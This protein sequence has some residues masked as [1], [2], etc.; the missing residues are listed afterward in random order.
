MR[1]QYRRYAVDFRTPLRT[2]AGVWTRREGLIVRAEQ[3]DGRVG[4]GE[5]APVP[6]FGM[7]TAAELAEFA[8]SLPTLTPAEVRPEI[9]PRLPTLAHAVAAAAAEAS[10]PLES[11]APAPGA[12]ERVATLQV[13]ALLPAGKAA[14][15]AAAARLESEFRVLKWK[16]G[17]GD[18]RDEVGLLDELCALLPEGARL[19]LDANGAWD[20]RTAERWLERCAE[21]PI[22][23]VEEPVGA[24]LNAEKRSDL[25]LGLAA[26]FPTPLALDESLVGEGDLERWLGAGWGGIYVVKPSL[27]ADAAAA[28]RRLRA[29]KAQVVFS[30][31]METAV[32][33][34]SALR[35][36]FAEAGAQPRA[37][38]FGTG[39]VFA[40]GRFDALEPAPFLRRF[41]VESLDPESVWNA[42]S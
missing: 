27:F 39:R 3:E 21:R 38:G 4:W 34:K 25:L 37:I 16:V 6:A 12:A 1:W 40:D 28:C 20:R 15:R 17:V 23:Y 42:L 24:G 8:A 13:A 35:L 5:A 9:S 36:A 2:G 7:E 31:A 26:D 30:S 33:A 41:D 19:R 22:E 29:A 11:T 10:V 18:W 32:G 14:V